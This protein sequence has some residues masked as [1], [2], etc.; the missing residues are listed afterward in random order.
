MNEKYRGQ[1]SMLVGVVAL[2]DSRH[3]RFNTFSYVFFLDKLAAHAVRSR[4]SKDSLF[5]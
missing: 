3:L 5:I 4:V 1:H 2:A